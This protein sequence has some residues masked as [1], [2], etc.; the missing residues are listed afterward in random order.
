M[1]TDD[2]ASDEHEVELKTVVLKR[3][4]SLQTATSTMPVSH[5]V[6]ISYEHP[7]GQLLR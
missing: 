5:Q 3:P 7:S 6:C 4:T 2:G 1:L